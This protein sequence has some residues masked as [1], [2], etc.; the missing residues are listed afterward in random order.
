[1]VRLRLQ[2][3]G[4]K[5]N[6]FYYIVAATNTSPRDGKHID[7]IG[8]F[9]PSINA[10]TRLKVDIESYD[11]WVKKGAKPSERV[12]NLVKQARKEQVNASA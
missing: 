7:K 3:Y 1:M 2:R 4:K 6:A 10:Q 8:Y 11:S 5:G 12:A 9:D